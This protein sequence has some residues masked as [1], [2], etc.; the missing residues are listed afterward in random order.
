MS[1]LPLSA[2]RLHQTMNLA[3]AGMGFRLV[4]GAL[5]L[6]SMSLSGMIWLPGRSEPAGL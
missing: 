2:L 5:L 4:C 6:G 1:A 3:P